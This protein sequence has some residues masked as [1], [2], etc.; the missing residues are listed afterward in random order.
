M[1]G[2]VLI[3]AAES[4]AWRR[5]LGA[6]AW[7]ALE[8][9]ALAAQPDE[10]GWAAPVGVRDV[11]TG[12]GVTKDTAARAVA[13]LGAA[14]LVAFA[15]VETTEGQRRTGYRLTL[16]EGIRLKQCPVDQ[17]TPSPPTRSDSPPSDQD[18]VRCI[19]N[20]DSTPDTGCLPHQDSASDVQGARRRSATSAAP[21]QPSLFDPVATE[22][23]RS[24]SDHVSPVVTA[25][26]DSRT[27]G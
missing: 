2:P 12:L 9:L 23:E 20:R 18:K 22:A 27:D 1:T 17:D 25:A 6:L 16:P 11:A 15:Q 19:P 5:R 13:A 10:M 24:G 4:R 26:S 8:H 7:A 21:A 14:G 3:V